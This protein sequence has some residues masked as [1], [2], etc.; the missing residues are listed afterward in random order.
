MTSAAPE[1][2]PFALEREG[3]ELAGESTGE[4]APIVL[5]HGLTASRRYI[6]HGSRLLP[7]SGFRTVS[8]DARGA[9]WMLSIADNG[10]DK[11]EDGASDA[12]AGLGTSIV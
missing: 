5:L 9:E 3:A 11:S 4:G 1:P 2:Q 12:K 6:V 8:Y 10:V 7:R